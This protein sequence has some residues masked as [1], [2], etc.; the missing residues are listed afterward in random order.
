M[1]RERRFSFIDTDAPDTVRSE[2]LHERSQSI[3]V[4]FAIA[5]PH[6][7]I[8]C[9]EALRRLVPWR[10]CD[11][12]CHAMPIGVSFQIIVLISDRG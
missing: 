12:V 11:G 9:P 1:K 7:R 8:I 10:G 2:R 3:S 4:L 5:K 6:R